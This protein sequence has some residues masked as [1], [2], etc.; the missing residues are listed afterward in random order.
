MNS[1]TVET[2]KIDHTKLIKPSTYAKNKGLDKSTVYLWLKD[3][4]KLLQERLRKVVID[5]TVFIQ[6]L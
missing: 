3:K 2:L 5:G 4:D 1:T 6:E